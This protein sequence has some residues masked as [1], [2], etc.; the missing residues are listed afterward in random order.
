MTLFRSSRSKILFFTIVKVVRLWSC[1]LKGSMG[2][3]MALRPTSKL[4]FKTPTR[5]R[6]I[7]EEL[8]GF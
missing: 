3:L 4:L 1:F 2:I 6:I 8:D 7:W 5:H